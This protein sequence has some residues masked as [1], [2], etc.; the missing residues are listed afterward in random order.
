MN[1]FDDKNI[2]KIHINVYQTLMRLKK[3]ISFSFFSELLQRFKNC[4]KQKNIESYLNLYNM[5]K[6]IKIVDDDHIKT[7]KV[8]LKIKNMHKNIY[9][10]ILRL[11]T[12]I[13][14][15]MYSKLLEKFKIC[16]KNKQINL[17]ID[18]NNF[19]K[20]MKQNK[21]KNKNEELLLKYH[22]NKE[23]IN[24]IK[25]IKKTKKVSLELEWDYR[26]PCDK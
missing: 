7:N 11:K 13:N 10:T 6:N 25:K 2:K 5:L 17:Y 23:K 12:K 26:N 20:N 14:F 19:L 4:K 18:L 8:S 24:K 15:T 3:K 9:K 21:N 22:N 16:K 1:K